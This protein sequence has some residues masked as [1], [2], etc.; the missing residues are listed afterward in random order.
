MAESDVQ[1]QNRLDELIQP[2][3]RRRLLAR[4]LARGL[5][6]HDGVLPKGAQP[7]S[8]S[9]TDDLL[10]YAYTVLAMALR[11]R[12]DDGGDRQI[13]Q[14]AF[15][16]AGESIEAAVHRGD[17]RRIDN[18]FNRV[19]A[20]VAFHLAG[21][22]ARAYSIIPTGANCGNLA[23]TERALVQLLRRSLDEMH[24]DVAAWLLAEEHQDN[25]IAQRLRGDVEF[26]ES[27]AIHIVLTGSFMRGLA[28]FGQAIT[29]GE[30]AFAAEAKHLMHLTMESAEDMH[31]VSHWWSATMAYHL[32]DDLWKLSLHCQ[33]PAIPP[34]GDNI[35][36]WTTLRRDYIQRLRASKRSIIELWPSQID[37]AHRAIDPADDL[38]VALPTSSGK[39]RIAELCI[40]RALASDQRVIYVTPLRALS[41]QVE[42]DLAETFQPL[43]I[44]VSSLYGSAGI[45]SSDVEVFREGQI[46]VSTPEKLD[47]ALRNDSSI[48]DDVGLIVL[49]EGSMLGP[50]ERG[51][52]YEALV[53]RLLRRSDAD[54]RRIVCLSALFPP[55]EEMK[56]FVS[57]LRQDEPGDAIYSTWRPTRQRYGNIIWNVEAGTALLVFK[58][59][60]EAPYVPRFVEAKEPPE[61]SRRRTPFP[62]D[63]D[64]LTL[65]AAW[66]F[67]AQEKNV[68]IFC[69][70]RRSV[71][72]LGRTI[73]QC[74]KHG[75][76]Q[77]LSPLSQDIQDAMATGTEWLGSDHPAVQCLKYGIALHHG[78][79]PRPFLNDVERLLR[80]GKIPLT[81]A[82]PTLAQGLNL[83]ASVL[84]VPSIWREKMIIPASEFANVAGRAG[85]AFVDLEGIILHIVWEKTQQKLSKRLREWNGLI[86]EAKAPTISSGLLKLAKI[87]FERISDAVG[88]PRED[89]IEYITGHGEAWDFTD[90]QAEKIGVKLTNWESDLASMDAA[91]L[92]LLEVDTEVDRLDA[93]LHLVLEGSL[94]SRQLADQ[95]QQMQL[96]LR[97]FIVARAHCIW[98]Q[99]SAPQ[100]RGYHVAGVG[101][102]AGQFLDSNIENLV[103]LLLRAEAAM[104]EEDSCATAD[105]IVEFA[106]LMFQTK[107]FKP[108]GA[109]PNA[110][111]NALRGWVEGRLASEVVGI[112]TDGKADLLQDA[113]SYRLP[114]A[115]EA[116]RVHAMAIGLEGAAQIQGYAAMAADVGSANRIVMKLLR[117]G[118]N[119]REAAIKAVAT[120]SATFTDHKGML[121]WLRSDQVRSMSDKE[122]W[123][124]KRSHHAWLQFFSANQMSINQ[125]FTCQTKVVEVEWF[126]DAP[127]V[128]T[129]IIIEPGKKLVLATDYIRLGVLRTDLNMLNR[130]IINAWVGN[131]LNTAV[132]EYF[133][134]TTD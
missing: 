129:R 12:S 72:K 39:T 107:P 36:K 8:D 6:W 37:A 51:V 110:W 69:A 17:P 113:F 11:L 62:N 90:A 83:S 65:A 26:D 122:D 98:T 28:L 105:A 94:F 29:T 24:A 80:L 88:V 19:S 33:I 97:R 118:L 52:R 126:I 55:P 91:I 112:A 38:I 100:R 16:V 130:D 61:G 27:D 133:G 131:D 74:I 79:L 41:A 10:D 67:V 40:L 114:W 45:A 47:F 111:D 3:F 2:G 57:W 4:G 70:Q 21:C 123:P 75:V 64:E 92:A 115:M 77:Q 34:N 20:A 1:L 46:V 54:F 108:S 104:V 128:N 121:E 119:S 102:R 59:Q 125:K 48:I 73:L 120:T 31:A 68:L 25:R 42:R 13:L 103:S 81:I 43:G 63:K 35:E 82:S 93:E 5:I 14:R 15:L 95:E 78:R 49:D 30:E 60:E 85:R 32:I 9:L 89:V 50:S 109:M 18:G 87:I 53:Q 134:P 106:K 84:L 99:T 116:V 22:A 117:S 56:D 124:T 132:V 71:E 7:F 96:L 127:P 23:P 86:S 58:V 66:Q 76:L 44:S 101:L